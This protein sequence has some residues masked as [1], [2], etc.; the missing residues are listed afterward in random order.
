MFDVN[1]G[2]NGSE[3]FA[4][5]KTRFGLF[6]ALSGGWIMT[7]EKFMENQ[8]IFDLLKLRISWGRVGNDKGSDNSRFMYMPATWQEG[9]SYSFGIDN[10]IGSP[11]FGIS[12][13]G[14]PNVTWETADK[15]NYGLDTRFLNS[16]L[17][18]NVDYFR[19]H[20]KGILIA[21]QSTPNII[22]TS[23]PNLN[24]GIV[25]IM[26]QLLWDV[27]SCEIFND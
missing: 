5:G 7:S 11:A 4:P 16:R 23:L 18:L 15:Q 19:E 1:M 6:P 25:V 21:P 8:N 2:Y 22:A 20:R 26:F 17:A 13:I 14:N 12:R 3:N 27:A 9:G 10:P 24:I